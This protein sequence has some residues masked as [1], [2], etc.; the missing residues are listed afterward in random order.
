MSIVYDTEDGY[1]NYIQDV[2]T[3]ALT[4]Q[5]KQPEESRPRKAHQ[6]HLNTES[7]GFAYCFLPLRV[8]HLEVFP[9]GRIVNKEY[10]LLAKMSMKNIRICA[11]TTV[12]VCSLF[13]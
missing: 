4:F 3:K 1:K 6:V 7:E 8:V 12:F 11:E 2:V 9:K 13:F 5:L 10:Y